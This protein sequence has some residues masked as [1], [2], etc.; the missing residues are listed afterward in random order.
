MDLTE[1]KQQFFKYL[2]NRK[3]RALSTIETYDKTLCQ[4]FECIGNKPASAL[5]IEDV[6]RYAD[7][8]FDKGNVAKTRRN[9][10]AVIRSFIRYLYKTD[11]TDIKPEKVEL[12]VLRKH[13]ANFL[14]TEEAQAFMSVVTDVRDRALMLTLLTTW[15]RISECLNIQLHDL[16]KQ[17]IIVR[18]GKGG[19]PRVVFIN[20]ETEKSI[21]RYLKERRG[22]HAGPL[23]LNKYGQQLK[24]RMVRRLVTRYAG[25]ANIQKPISPHTLRHTGAT[26]FIEAGGSLEE[27]Q[28][29]LG[30]SNI[31]TTRMYLHFTNERLR[32]SF[33]KATAASKY[34]R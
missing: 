30:H 31:Y 21:K 8:M 10:L 17:S 1:A 12:P 34:T 22:Y 28:Q 9:R 33:N 15:T 18:V 7:Y 27:A 5:T 19:S 32:E 14:T 11:M 2:V 24:P 3:N 23:F 16:Y 13:E 6:D 26:G 20:E 4:F 29:I 25:Q